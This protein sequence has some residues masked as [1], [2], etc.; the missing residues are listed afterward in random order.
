MTTE[1]EPFRDDQVPPDDSLQPSQK[2]ALF[3]RLSSAIMQFIVHTL[4]GRA[5]SAG[6]NPG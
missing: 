6:D 3:V 2:A 5:P 4:P 1:K